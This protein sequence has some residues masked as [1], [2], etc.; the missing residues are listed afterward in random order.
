MT[1]KNMQPIK[2]KQQR[3]FYTGLVQLIANLVEYGYVED[4][5]KLTI[6]TLAELKQRID[7]RLLTVKKEYNI[8]LTHPQAIA[9]RLLYT[10]F[11]NEFKTY[12]CNKLFTIA[13]QVQKNYQ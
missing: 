8:T 13:N 2:L 10:G 7:V 11:I 12:L 5:D 4:T 6:A 3:A 9:M 1:S